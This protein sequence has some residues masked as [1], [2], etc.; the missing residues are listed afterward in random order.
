MIYFHIL[1]FTYKFKV[2]GPNWMAV[3]D[4][5][6]TVKR[7]RMLCD[8]A[9]LCYCVISFVLAQAEFLNSVLKSQ[10]LFCILRASHQVPTLSNSFQSKYIVSLSVFYP[11]SFMSGMFP[12][13][14]F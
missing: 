9:F 4:L 2:N 7:L 14:L 11:A 5:F 12:S 6:S 1:L 3:L 10:V 8:H 13:S